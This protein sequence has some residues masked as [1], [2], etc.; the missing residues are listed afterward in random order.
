MLNNP[1]T[2]LNYQL[3]IH[4]I[5]QNKQLSYSYEHGVNLITLDTLDIKAT[6]YVAAAPG[7]GEDWTEGVH[8]DRDDLV[9]GGGK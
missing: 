6:I 4:C 2:P 5:V 1:F 8:G 9:Q 7:R 3:M